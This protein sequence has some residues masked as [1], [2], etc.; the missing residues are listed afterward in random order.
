MNPKMQSLR[1]ASVVAIGFLVQ[2]QP[3]LARGTDVHVKEVASSE[4]VE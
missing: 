3:V 4:G 2:L 1:G